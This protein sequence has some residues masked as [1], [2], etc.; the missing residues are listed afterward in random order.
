MVPQSAIAISKLA[1][2]ASV[3]ASSFFAH[4]AILSMNIGHSYHV[5]GILGI[6]MLSG[7]TVFAKF[8]NFQVVSMNPPAASSL[9][10]TF[11]AGWFGQSSD[12]SSVSG[13][14]ILD[15]VPG[16]SPFTGAHVT[17]LDLT[18]D[19][20]LKFSLA[21]G[22]VRANSAAGDLMISMTSPGPAAI[23]SGGM[24]DQ[25][26]NTFA[27]SGTVNTNVQGSIDLL[28]LGPLAG[29][30][31]NFSLS[32]VGDQITI[33]TPISI[34]QDTVI[35]NVPFVGN[36]P[37]TIATTGT[38]RAP[39]TVVPG[40]GDM[41]WDGM[42]PA[43]GSPGDGSSWNDALNWTR[44]GIPDQP[45]V[46]GDNVTFLTVS[47]VSSVNLQGD[48]LANRVNFE[49]NYA[50]NNNT[51]TVMTG[52]VN[53]SSNVTATLN[54]N[55]MA[56]TGTIMKQGPGTLLV[57]GTASA[58]SV[59]EGTLGGQGSIGGVTVQ[60]GAV[61]APGASTGI[62]QV[63]GSFTQSAG[64]TLAMEINGTTPG[65]GHDPLNIS[66][67]ATLEGKLD[68]QTLSLP[69]T[70]TAP[71][72]IGDNFT[73]VTFSPLPV[74]FSK[75]ER[76]HVGND[77][78]FDLISHDNR[79][80]L[81]AWH[82]LAGD[83]DGNRDMDITDFNLLATNFSPTKNVALTRLGL[84]PEPQTGVLLGTLLVM[85]VAGSRRVGMAGG[86]C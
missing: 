47:S 42:N 44:V 74:G 22:A 64:S 79:L 23:V 50:M 84:L 63:N 80:E 52:E 4:I 59:E 48:R 5:A 77:L 51:L 62:L 2:R 10:I 56:N 21:F 45:F 16:T 82:A 19:E 72:T 28:T 1:R 39:G 78:F 18:L 14:A 67:T 35:E 85:A 11:D 31:E 41:E 6:V 24:F 32:Q 9:N 58:I 3:R 73:F 46:A 68:I 69:T 81:G 40:V 75:I 70:G 15:L 12:S 25:L 13:T 71:R 38:I 61:V 49:A 57:N 60:P 33:E 26:G 30:L 66:R 27:A 86:S 36:I 37:V 65:S 8:I 76:L 43:T 29:N 54:S 83:A 53:V 20:A 55:I 17:S 34:V 7:I